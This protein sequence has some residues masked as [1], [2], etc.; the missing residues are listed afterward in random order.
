VLIEG[1]HFQVYDGSS[2][3][4]YEGTLPE[5]EGGEAGA[6]DKVPRSRGSSRRSTRRASKPT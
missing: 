6:E 4:V 3:T 5:E 1:H 2:E